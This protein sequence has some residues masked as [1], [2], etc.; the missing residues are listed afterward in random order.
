MDGSTAIG[1]CLVGAAIKMKLEAIS[2]DV[3]VDTDTRAHFLG[4]FSV[5]FNMPE[6]ASSP[7]MLTPWMGR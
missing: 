6:E 3:S 7:L 5:L 4:T 1:F 2:R